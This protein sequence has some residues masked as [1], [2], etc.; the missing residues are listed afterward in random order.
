V[1]KK[2]HKLPYFS[3]IASCFCPH[4]KKGERNQQKRYFNKSANNIRATTYILPVCEA[5]VGG[6]SWDCSSS[7]QT[8]SLASEGLIISRTFWRLAI[9]TWW[10]SGSV[11]TPCARNYTY[12]K[13][14]VKASSEYV[15]F[16]HKTS[17]GP[18][19][20]DSYTTY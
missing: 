17:C 13:V 18:I 20:S 1:R 7:N 9:R 2:F 12:F 6:S 4:T 5:G 16:W 15:E 11:V 3:Y 14:F 8:H 19:A 10:Q